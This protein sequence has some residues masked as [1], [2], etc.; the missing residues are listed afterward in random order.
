M[1]CTQD[2][3]TCLVIRIAVPRLT[4]T[5]DMFRAEATLVCNRDCVCMSRTSEGLSLTRSNVLWLGSAKI[6]VNR[7]R[8]ARIISTDLL[9]V[10]ILFQI[11][12]QFLQRWSIFFHVMKI[13][14]KE[15]REKKWYLRDIWKIIRVLKHYWDLVLTRRKRKHA[16]NSRF[17]SARDIIFRDDIIFIFI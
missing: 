3:E 1:R 8:H 17:T 2:M 9:R 11:T 13:L 12:T 14:K 7:S 16:Y 5:E 6:H 15:K 10:T 4:T